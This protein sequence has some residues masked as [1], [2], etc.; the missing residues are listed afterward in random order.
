MLR[1]QPLMLVDDGVL[2]HSK[3]VVPFPKAKAPTS[4][5]TSNRSLNG[6]MAVHAHYATTTR[7]TESSPG[8]NKR[9]QTI[10]SAFSLLAG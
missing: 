9:D 7:P 1:A 6:E 5:N 10:A 8:T 4:R 2:H 3:I